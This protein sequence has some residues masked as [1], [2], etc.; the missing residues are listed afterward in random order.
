[1]VTSVMKEEEDL[2][3]DVGRGME[4]PGRRHLSRDLRCKWEV[5]SSLFQVQGTAHVCFCAAQELGAFAKKNLN[6]I[7]I[8]VGSL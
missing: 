7:L 4:G 6:F 1:M 8:T 3:L 2:G 5:A